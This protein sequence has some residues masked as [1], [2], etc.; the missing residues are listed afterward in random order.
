MQT[1][2]GNFPIGFRRTLADWQQRDMAGLAQWAKNA[3]F[4]HLDLGWATRA[5]IDAV[6][7]GRTRRALVWFV[8]VEGDWA[9]REDEL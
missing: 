3:G 7:D 6:H 5:D 8:G 2:T 4:A 9:V 1:R